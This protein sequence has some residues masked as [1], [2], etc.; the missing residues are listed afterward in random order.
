MFFGK[1]AFSQAKNI[2]SKSCIIKNT[3]LEL[4]ERLSHKYSANVY[5]KRED[6]QTVR[7][8][9]V[10]GAYYKI[11]TNYYNNKDI[12]QPRPAGNHAQG[13]ATT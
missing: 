3:P 5:V 2:I 12:S 13:V 7:S 10:R 9:K 8:F 1:K 4:N 6:L 11:F